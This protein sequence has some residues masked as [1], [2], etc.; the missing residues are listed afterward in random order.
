MSE[1][2]PYEPPQTEIKPAPLEKPL[3]PATGSVVLRW[4]VPYMVGLQILTAVLTIMF[5]Y[6]RSPL[7][8]FFNNALRITAP[9]CLG[10]GVLLLLIATVQ[11][12]TRIIIFE[13]LV[14]AAFFLL[15]MIHVARH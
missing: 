5:V 9:C 13:L 14:L 15:Q 1:L 4:F 2:N 8:G 10:L 6:L 7:S 12:Y 11:K 3:T